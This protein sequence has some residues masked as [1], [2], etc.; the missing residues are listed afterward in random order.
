MV[1][2]PETFLKGVKKSAGLG[3]VFG[4]RAKLPFHIGTILMLPL[5]LERLRIGKFC[6]IAHGVRLITSSANR[7]MSG[8]S[9]Y[10]FNNIE[11]IEANIDAIVGGSIEALQRASHPN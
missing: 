9:T 3:I 10:P 5:R 2:T 11:K 8:F 6:Q 4:V 7:D 1:D